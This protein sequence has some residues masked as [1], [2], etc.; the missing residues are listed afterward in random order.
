MGWYEDLYEDSWYEDGCFTIQQ[1]PTEDGTQW[2]RVIFYGPEPAE[3]YRQTAYVTKA[4]LLCM[5]RA[6]DK[7]IIAASIKEDR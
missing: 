4:D 1:E 6:I 2:F 7:A 5:R 3:S